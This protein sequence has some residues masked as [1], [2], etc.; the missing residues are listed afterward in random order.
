MNRVLLFGFKPHF[1]CFITHMQPF[2]YGEG[3]IARSISIYRIDAFLLGPA[4]LHLIPP[5]NGFALTTGASVAMTRALPQQHST[6]CLR[7]RLV[8]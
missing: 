2:G 1:F 3:Y 8:E 6:R 5:Y 7:Q 4:L